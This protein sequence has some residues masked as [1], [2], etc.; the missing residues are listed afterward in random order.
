MDDL[1]EKITQVLNDPEQM[2]QIMAIAKSLGFPSPDE[3]AQTESEPPLTIPPQLTQLLSQAS[4]MER[5]QDALLRALKPFLQ[6]SRQ[7]K[8]D[9]AMQVARI[10]QLAG[11]ALK[12]RS[13]EP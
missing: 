2:E 3:G 10:S 6:P 7:E 13:K 8:I 1:E 5:R 11:Y 12:N 9:K 4:R